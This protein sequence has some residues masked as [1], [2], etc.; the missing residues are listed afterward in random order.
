MTHI[1]IHIQKVIYSP[2]PFFLLG[3][4]TFNNGSQAMDAFYKKESAHTIT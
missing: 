1:Q 3:Q 2:I 4:N